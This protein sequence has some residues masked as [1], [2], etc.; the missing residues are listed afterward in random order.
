MKVAK[1]K[2]KNLRAYF[3]SELRKINKVPKTGSHGSVKET[4]SWSYFN[5]LMFLRDT[6]GTYD[7][8]RDDNIS[9][10][11]ADCS[12]RIQGETAIEEETVDEQ[13]ITLPP[14][15]DQPGIDITVQPATNSGEAQDAFPSRY[16]S[17]NLQ[18]RRS[19]INKRKLGKAGLEERYTAGKRAA[20]FLSV[21]KRKVAL[22]EKEVN[23]D[24]N[25]DLQFFKSLI[26]YMANF[27]PIQ[28]LRIRSK[29]QDII[30]QE[31]EK[32]STSSYSDT[33]QDNSSYSPSSGT[34][35]QLTYTELNS[36]SRDETGINW[37][38]D[39]VLYNPIIAN[40]ML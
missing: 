25:P 5:Q 7:E 10:Q 31:H 9:T 3:V 21:E 39:P 22:L 6:L 23:M 12:Q 18:L 40:P 28:K 11:D 26:P 35:N 19:N 34:S 27:N 17:N 24:S 4:S 8:A 32:A 1:S 33:S 16:S 20:E 29:I 13:E 14:T 38:V 36:T 37:E 2:W 15:T 30:L